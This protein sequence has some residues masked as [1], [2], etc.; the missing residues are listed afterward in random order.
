MLAFESPPRPQVD[1]DRASKT[2]LDQIK[3]ALAAAVNLGLAR[4]FGLEERELVIDQRSDKDGPGCAASL[5]R[6]GAG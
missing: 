4:H 3:G 5:P 1:P 6:E 2:P